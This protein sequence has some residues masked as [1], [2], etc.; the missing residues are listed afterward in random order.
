MA[1]YTYLD[2]VIPGTSELALDSQ[3]LL[4][5]V[6]VAGVF[7]VGGKILTSR[8]S[9][10][11]G[12]DSA[13]VPDRKV[14]LFGLVDLLFESA[15]KFQD[16]VMGKKNRKFAPFI[17]TLFFFIFSLNVLSLIPG[18][19]VS[20][21]TVWLNVGMALVVF[22]H[23]NYHGI[24][25][26]GLTGYLKHFWGPVFLLGPFIMAVEVLSLTIRILTLNMR[27]YWNISGDHIVLSTFVEM[28][29]VALAFPFYFLGLFVS[30]MQALIF[31]ILTMIYILLATE[32]GE[33]H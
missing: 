33:E 4:F 7:I 30:F 18:M 11:E 8:L 31:S 19:P 23:F 29:P 14:S 32:H 26:Q 16:S 21:T 5:A 22:I 6:A 20:T 17:G 12:V 2:H 24:K 27:L 15:L 25:E 9:T 13:V 1:H 10:P 28:L 3:K